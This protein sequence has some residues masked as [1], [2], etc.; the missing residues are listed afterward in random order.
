[1]KIIIK[2]IIQARENKTKKIRRNED[3]EKEEVEQETMKE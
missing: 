3:R 2:S 1:M